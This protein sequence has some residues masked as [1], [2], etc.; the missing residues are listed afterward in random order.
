M[1]LRRSFYAGNAVADQVGNTG[2]FLGQFIPAEL[3]IRHQR[4]LELKWGIHQKGQTRSHPYANGNGTTISVLVKGNFR[5]ALQVGTISHTVTL[6][7]EGDYVVFGPDVVHSW[8]AIADT[9]VLSVRFPS[10]EV[11]PQGTNSAT[12]ASSVSTADR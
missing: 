10:V 4:D 8:Q 3:G 9:I 2:W 6:E 1:D 5:V 11:A 7:K 12:T